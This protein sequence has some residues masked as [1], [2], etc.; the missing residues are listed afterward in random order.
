MKNRK[1]ASLYYG[2]LIILVLILSPYLLFISQFF[3]EDAE[4]YKTIFGEIKSGYFG[5]IQVFVHWIFAKFVPLLLLSILY[6]TNKHWW[7]PAILVPI[8]VYLFQL[9]SVFNDSNEHADE[10]EFIYTIP[11]LIIVSFILYAIRRRLVI[12]TKALDLKD[13]MEEVINK[14][15]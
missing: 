14:S 9:I 13:E 1:K 6:I 3:P 10:V 4:T 7:S 5:N 11:I 12:Y 8:S 2:S 15:K